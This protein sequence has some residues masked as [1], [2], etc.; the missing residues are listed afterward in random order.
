MRRHAPKPKPLHHVP[1]VKVTAADKRHPSHEMGQ[2]V[3]IIR[4]HPVVRNVRQVRTGV[5]QGALRVRVGLFEGRTTRVD[6]VIREGE[7]FGYHLVRPVYPP[8]RERGG[9]VHQQ[10]DHSSEPHGR[11]AGGRGRATLLTRLAHPRAC[12]LRKSGYQTPCPGQRGRRTASRRTRAVHRY[13]LPPVYGGGNWKSDSAEGGR[14]GE[15][16]LKL[17]SCSLCDRFALLD[18]ASEAVVP[19]MSPMTRQYIRVCIHME[20]RVE[21]DAKTR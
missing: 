21:Y 3:Y 17:S 10:R 20:E 12:A 1:L 9:A 2:P 14:R 11:W 6:A 19:G 13:Q 18:F 5:R 4:P 15:T 7:P 8:T 16:Y